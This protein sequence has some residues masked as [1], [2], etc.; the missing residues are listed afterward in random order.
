MAIYRGPKEKIERKFG[1]P[2]FH[3]GKSLKKRNYAPGQHGKARKKKS[4][5]ALQLNEKQKAKY[6]YGLLERQ[7]RNLFEKAVKNKGITR[8]ILMQL[9]ESRLDNIVYRMGIAPSRKAAR[10]LISHKHITV[11]NSVVNIPSYSTVVGD[12]ISL[13]DKSKLLS[14]VQNCLASNKVRYS[15]LEWDK[16]EML[17]KIMACPERRDIPEKIDEQS[18]VELYSK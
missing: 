11:N 3:K 18:I 14:A 4:S 8:E 6:I 7:F 13:R 15:W 16:I 17:G 5:Y 1:E 12:I 2:I 9:L 10:Q